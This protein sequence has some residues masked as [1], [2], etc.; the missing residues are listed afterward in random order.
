MS[1]AIPRILIFYHSASG[2]TAWITFQ[3]AR[4]LENEGYCVVSRNIALTPDTSDISS[5][6]LIGFG[7]PVMGFR[8]TFSM[9]DFI[10]SLPLHLEKPA[11]IF[12]TYAGIHANTFWTLAKK[13]RSRGL[14]VIA[15]DRFRGEVSWPIARAIG[16]IINRSQPDERTLPHLTRFATRIA[17]LIKDM[18][19]GSSP[20]NVAIPFNRLNPFYYLSLMVYPDRLRIIMGT[21]GVNKNKCTHCGCCKKYC[22]V[23][24]ITLSPFPSFT[25]SCNG[26]WGCYN[27]CP[28]GAITTIVGTLGR[29][30]AKAY[31]LNSEKDTPL[32][33]T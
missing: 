14:T 16:L 6:D 31:L 9:T 22:P 11:F 27:I 29:Y 13:I 4:A 25:P 3:L 12:T 28:E 8:P 20:A 32:Q 24:A 15:Y 21:K 33:K 17:T 7:C 18:S 23:G 19:N 1:T 26:C 30:R 5:Y 10:S 2:N